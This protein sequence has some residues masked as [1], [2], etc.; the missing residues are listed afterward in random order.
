MSFIYQ[1]EECIFIVRWEMALVP[2]SGARKLGV[3]S[4]NIQRLP[5]LTAPRGMWYGCGGERRG[6][7]GE[8]GGAGGEQEG[9]G[10]GA[11]GERNEDGTLVYDLY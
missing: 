4:V 2:P 1:S 5:Q 9:S 7:G 3:V 6:E 8:K 11:G 10:R